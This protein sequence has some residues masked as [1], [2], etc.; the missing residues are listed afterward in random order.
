MQT[1]DR[2]R[3]RT[4]ERPYREALDL[5][6]VDRHDFPGARDSSGVQD[7]ISFEARLMFSPRE[8]SSRDKYSRTEKTRNNFVNLLNRF[9]KQRGSAATPRFVSARITRLYKIGRTNGILKGGIYAR[10][11]VE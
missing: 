8:F 3:A 1:N 7:R 10:E 11:T 5:D 6:P 2:S 4:I 9:I